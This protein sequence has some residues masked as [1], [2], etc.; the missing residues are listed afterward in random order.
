MGQPTPPGDMPLY[1]GLSSEWNDIVGAFPEDKRNELAPLLKQRIDGFQE[2]I[3]P[4]EDLTKSGITPEHASTALNLFNVIENNPREVYETIGKYLGITP[5]AA[6][7]AV[8]EMED[9]GATED[10]RLATLQQQVDT[11]AQI[12]LAQRQQ[13]A[14]E[15]QAADQDAAIEKELGSLKSKYGDVDEEEI[16]MRMLHNNMTAEQAYQSYAAK[17]SQ[18]RSTRPAPMLIG[19]GGA[20]PRKSI[21]VTKLDNAD[22]KNLV[23]QMMQHAAVEKRS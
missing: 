19:G 5:A 21:D 10:P 7:E 23:A 6:K 2:Q 14:A 9:S 22:T 16:L 18:I 1:E 4:W 8:E 13:T 12:A 15:K 20:V 17:V 11:L 3:K